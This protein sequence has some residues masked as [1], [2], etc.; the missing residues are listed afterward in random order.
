MPGLIFFLLA[1]GVVLLLLGR[2]QATRM[3]IPAGRI[4]YIDSSSLRRQD[5]PFYDRD[6]DLLGRPDYLIETAKGPVPLELKSGPSPATPYESHI[7]QLAAY[8]RLVQ[9]TDGRRPS[10]GVLKYGD[11]SF[12]IDYTPGLENALLDILAEMRR[13]ESAA[14]DRS[15]EAPERCR[16]CGYRQMCD[17][18]LV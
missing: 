16:G 5:R 9:A 4:V 8:C 6:L 11:R 3:G 17:Q 1:L 15:H 12:A 13:G 14:Q 10:H 7:L 18:R 2:R